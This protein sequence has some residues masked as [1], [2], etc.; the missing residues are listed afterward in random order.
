MQSAFRVVAASAIVVAASFVI[1][2]DTTP[3]SQSSEIQ[4]QL[5]D[6]LFS[7]GKFLESLEAYRISLKDATADNTRRPRM[8]VIASALRVA[9]FGLARTEAEKLH[10]A[11]PKGPEAMTLYGDAL[12]SSG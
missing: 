10:Q 9:E 2:A 5:G 6:L 3:S 11:D 1:R 7:E 8:G 4:L 12:W